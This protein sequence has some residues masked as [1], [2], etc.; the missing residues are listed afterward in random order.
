MTSEL[1]TPSTLADLIDKELMGIDPDSQCVVLDDADWRLITT[2]LRSAVPDVPELVRYSVPDRYDKVM[3]D[4]E[5][6]LHSQA[7]EI[8][9]EEQQK[10]KDAEEL[11]FRMDRFAQKYLSHMRNAK[12]RAEAAESKLAQY[13]A[14]HE[15]EMTEVIKE[16]DQCEAW[17]DKLAHAIGGEAIGEHSN[18][19]NPWANALEIAS[20][21]APA[22]DLKAANERLR[23]GFRKLMSGYVNTL[24]NG[25]DRIRSLGGS[26]D[27]L[28]TMINNDPYL[29]DA[30]AALNVEA[31]NDKG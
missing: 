26:C 18:M 23:A 13:E 3:P 27:D 28:D 7:A 19:N 9:A 15:K 1:H 17:A 8:I 22:E 30:R 10:T 14:Q 24:E 29:R 25:M 4:G 20:S 21:P 2:A 31:S 16:R 11:A 5:Y 12:Q 6:V